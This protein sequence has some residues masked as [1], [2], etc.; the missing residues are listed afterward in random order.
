MSDKQ[1]FAGG[2]QGT[3]LAST[4]ITGAV[5]NQLSAVIQGLAQAKYLA[6]EAEFN[7]GSGGTTVDAYV[8][9]SLDGGATWIDI[10]NFHFTTT[11]G[12]RV[13]AVVTSTALAANVTPTDGSLTAST[14]LSGL[15]GDRIRV[16][17]TTTGTYAGGTTL[18]LFFNAKG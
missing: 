15:L 18:A 1:K 11:S 7:Y 3:L 16:K 13:S 12:N 14:I 9:T 17:Y 5:S 4:T 10:M 6:V 8:Q 2:L